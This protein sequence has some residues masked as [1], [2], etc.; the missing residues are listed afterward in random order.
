[1]KS[2]IPIFP[3][4][5]VMFPEARYPLHIFEERYKRMIKWCIDN[6]TEFGIVL[7]IDLKI[8]NVDCIM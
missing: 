2:Q 3:L 8:A 5:L 4:N 7:K 1:M 6:D